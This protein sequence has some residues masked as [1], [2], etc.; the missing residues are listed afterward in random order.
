M[1]TSHRYHYSLFL[2]F[3]LL[4]LARFCSFFFLHHNR[5]IH[6]DANLH[7]VTHV[8]YERT[9]LTK[10]HFLLK[11]SQSGT[12]RRFTE[13]IHRV[14]YIHKCFF[15][16]RNKNCNCIFAITNANASILSAPCIPNIRRELAIKTTF[17]ECVC[18]IFLAVNRLHDYDSPTRNAASALLPFFSSSTSN[19]IQMD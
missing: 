2:L 9:K 17:A 12:Q 1:F 8:K 16:G 10:N 14:R 7:T 4:T 15:Y 13:I 6:F 3:S 11:H 5:N 19:A 18:L